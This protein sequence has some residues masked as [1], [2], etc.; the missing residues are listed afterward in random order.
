MNYY[1]NTDCMNYD[2]QAPHNFRDIAEI[3]PGLQIICL[4]IMKH[5][6]EVDFILLFDNKLNLECIR[7]HSCQVIILPEE[8]RVNLNLT[9]IYGDYSLMG[10]LYERIVRFFTVDSCRK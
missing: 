9:I 3:N 6:D 10:T 4:P 2:I 8:P 1:N 5:G 7:G